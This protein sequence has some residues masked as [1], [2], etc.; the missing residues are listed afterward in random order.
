MRSFAG[1]ADQDAAAPGE[2]AGRSGCLRS[3]A[4]A[5]PPSPARPA[6]DPAI[7]KIV[8][9]GVT[10]RMRL[11]AVSAISIPPFAISTTSDGPETEAGGRGAAVAG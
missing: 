5:G 3:P 2:T 1:V 9:S 8:P 7:V 11:L 4:L 10:R 6:V